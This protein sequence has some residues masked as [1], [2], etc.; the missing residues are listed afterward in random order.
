MALM[1]RLTPTTTVSTNSPSGW[2]YSTDGK[3]GFCLATV[4]GFDY[5]T[6]QQSGGVLGAVLYLY[7]DGGIMHLIGSEAD[8]V[9]ALVKG[10]DKK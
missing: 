3:R 9:Y 8:A 1:K 5:R 10:K 4:K 7:L 2:W 6:V